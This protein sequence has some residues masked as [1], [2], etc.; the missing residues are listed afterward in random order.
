MSDSTEKLTL[1]SRGLEN[2]PQSQDRNDFTF[3]VG[4]VRYSCPSFVAEFLSPK[5]CSLHETDPTINE[6]SIETLDPNRHF[7]DF[8]R[9]GLGQSIEVGDSAR[10]FFV[11]VAEELEN[12]ELGRFFA[13][14]RD[15]KLTVSNAL[16]CFHLCYL[17]HFPHAAELEFVS[18]HFS[19]FVRR[20]LDVFSIDELTEIFGHSSLELESEDE[21][22]EFIISHSAKDLAYFALFEFVRFEYLSVES[23]QQFS[24]FVR[25][26]FDCLNVSV[27][28]CICR[29]LCHRV[30]IDLSKSR[31]A[32]RFSPN[33]SSS[34]DGIISYLSRQCGGNV[35]T[36]GVVTITGNPY[37][38]GSR[39]HAALNAANL[40]EN[41]YFYSKNEPNQMLTYDFGDRRIKPTH[42]S[43]RSRHD[44]NDDNVYLRSWVIEGSIDGQTWRQL[45]RREDD[46]TLKSGNK[47]QVFEVH[48]S[49]DCR[50]VRLHQTGPNHYSRPDNCLV[51][52]GFELFGSLHE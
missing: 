13:K 40:T 49:T 31:F 12:R 8:L 23:V 27:W 48:L 33:S 5:L 47:I 16:E 11:S 1:T 43:I 52:S 20:D 2:I 14:G 18:S 32:R 28:D 19:E 3:L 25:E 45:D 24:A 15:D 35:H 7:E 29:R 51:V 22:C 17:G 36:K 42:Y 10:S 41:S 50:L 4:D 38:D 6:F 26:H 37:S 39:S 21:L 30:Q 46:F 34:I 44:G 9:L